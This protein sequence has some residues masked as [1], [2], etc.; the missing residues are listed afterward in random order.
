[1]R[2]CDTRVPIGAKGDA[3]VWRS[4]HVHAQI[5]R[6]FSHA[7][8]PAVAALFVTFEGF[9]RGVAEPTAVRF[10]NC[11]HLAALWILV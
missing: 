11:G 1:M 10:A 5:A 9:R 6:A 7:T 3:T 8:V 4:M 2:M